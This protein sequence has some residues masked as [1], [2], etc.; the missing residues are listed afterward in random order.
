MIPYCIWG[1]GFGNSVTRM[2]ML[3]YQNSPN[4]TFFPEDGSRRSTENVACSYQKTW[5]HSR[6]A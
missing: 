4:L 6:R 5:C 1:V 3:G 2:I